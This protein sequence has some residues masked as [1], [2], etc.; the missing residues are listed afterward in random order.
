MRLLLD[1]HA[2]LWWLT[3]NPRLGPKTRA[4]ISKN[5]VEVLVSVVSLWEATIKFGI[6]KLRERGSEL[7]ADIEVEALT[8]LA[9]S[10]LHM[11][12]L[13]ELPRHHS[14]PFDHILIAQAQVEGVRLVT[15][16]R[17]MALYGVACIAA[18]Q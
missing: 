10:R 1:T 12:A 6:G 17:Q 18:M 8:P 11:L 13:E 14:D 4:L 9:I 3:D 15:V 2:L 5:D 16:D 7:W